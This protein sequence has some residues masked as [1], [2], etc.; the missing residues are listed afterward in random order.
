MLFNSHVFLFVVLPVT[1]A[2]LLLLRRLPSTAPMRLWLLAAS[3]VFYGWWSLA[4]LALLL[5]SILANHLLGRAI[6]RARAARPALAWRLTALGVAANLALLGWF[7][8]ATFVAGNLAALGGLDLAVQA[9]AL[10]LAISFYTFQ[11]IAYLVDVRRG[12]AGDYGLLDYALFVTFFPQL[13]AGPIV[14]HKELVPQFHDPRSGRLDPQDVA[15]GLVFLVIGLLKKLA[16]ADP[17]GEL[18]APTFAA[19]GTPGALEAWLAVGAFTLGLYFDFSAYSDMAVGLARMCGMRLPYN[20]ASPYQAASIVEFWRRWHM[21]LSRFLRD[22]LY[23][24]LGGNRHGAARRHLNLMLTMLLGG[25]WHGAGW[26][27]I[28]WGA[29][30]GTYLLVNHAWSRAVAA[31]RARALPLPVAR[32]VTLL[33]VMLAWVFFAAPGFDVALSVLS[34]MAGLH[35]IGPRPPVVGTLVDVLLGRVPVGLEG[36][37]GFPALVGRLG[38]LAAFAL[39]WAIVLAAPNSQQIVDGAAG[40][41]GWGA[42]WL[43]FRPTAAAA[44]ATAAGFVAALMLMADVKEFVYFQF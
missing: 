8:Y 7:K 21:T 34:G 24:P 6:G 13:I 41:R 27:F 43:R 3:L 10:P 1:L 26:T 20:F 39:G 11:Q 2:G 33:A 35:G 16:L 40:E 44:V 15:A 28:A 22:Y 25:I 12:E 37:A 38:S 4:H 36:E 5:A 23:I 32:G 30:H 31:G 18:A 9:V 19:A 17:I 42:A 14:H 29:L